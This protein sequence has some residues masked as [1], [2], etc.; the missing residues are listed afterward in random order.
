MGARGGLVA[1]LGRQ[2]AGGE[3]EGGACGVGADLGPSLPGQGL[4]GAPVARATRGLDA[5]RPRPLAERPARE[6]A[7]DGLHTLGVPRLG[8][9]LGLQHGPPVGRDVRYPGEGGVAGVGVQPDE[10]ERAP[11]PGRPALDAHAGRV[12]RG[13]KRVV[14]RTR[15]LQV[16][17]VVLGARQQVEAAR[18][19]E[20]VRPAG[21][22]QQG[23]DALP[24][25]AARLGAGGEQARLG[26]EGG[27]VA[28]VR[29]QEAG[30]ALGPVRVEVG[31][32]LRQDLGARTGLGSRVLDGVG[33]APARES[34][35][36]HELKNAAEH[37]ERHGVPMPLAPC[38]LHR[39]PRAPRRHRAGRGSGPPADWRR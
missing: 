37:G 17:R 30:G 39:R 3:G 27:G 1:G 16:A 36:E 32:R 25:A 26:V 13:Q 2:L 14:A 20:R 24:V 12:G 38:R 22:R 18:A 9:R 10:H 6:P 29:A 7:G 31:R 15:G 23:A 8:Q 19:A 34:G 33:A 21:A 11:Q 5:R 35:Q 28:R 4:G